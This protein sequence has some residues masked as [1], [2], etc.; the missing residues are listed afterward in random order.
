M[1]KNSL[2]DIGEILKSEFISIFDIFR[3]FI[4][5]TVN[6]FHSKKENFN[7]SNK[8]DGIYNLVELLIE[9]NTVE[10]HE[11]E[12]FGKTKPTIE[13]YKKNIH[14][15][16][17]KIKNET[18]GEENLKIIDKLESKMNEN[19]DYLISLK[20]KNENL[21]REISFYENTLQNLNEK[22]R[23]EALELI[24]NKNE[25]YENLYLNNLSIKKSE[26]NDLEENFKDKK[27]EDLDKEVIK[28]LN[29]KELAIQR[30][31][32]LSEKLKK[33]ENEKKNKK[34]EQKS[35]QCNFF[36]F[37]DMLKKNFTFLIKKPEEI[38]EGAIQSRQWTMM[39][40]NMIVNDK[41]I[42]DIINFNNFN[43]SNSLKKYTISWFVLKFGSKKAG[44]IMLKDFLVSL[45]NYRL[46]IEFIMK[47]F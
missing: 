34:F 43:S 29:E 25:K 16:K 12:I 19:F 39:I 30:N 9:L 10:Y 6:I 33:V 27:I 15:E 13:E 47:F 18:N 45:K 11:I 28:I 32:N 41:L 17:F 24:R 35:I 46:F 3:K 21:Q 22:I 2:S 38:F 42:S 37:S 40:I 23:V 8:V 7:N 36:N 44:N 31:K 26:K 1:S 14:L 5:N 4:E 20:N